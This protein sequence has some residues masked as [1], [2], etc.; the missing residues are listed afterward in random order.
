MHRAGR[1]TAEALDMLVPHVRPGVTT[2]ALDRL[3]VDF[4]HGHGAAPAPL[5]YRGYPKAICTWLA[6]SLLR[7]SSRRVLNY[8]RRCALRR[9]AVA[10]R[11]TNVV[12]VS[13]NCQP[14]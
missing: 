14:L 4:A 11:K 8:L 13:C 10:R 9:R 3:V 2:D 6:L 5:Y 12:Q 7:R 1:L